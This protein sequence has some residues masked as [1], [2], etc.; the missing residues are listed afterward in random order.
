MTKLLGKKNFDSLLGSF[1]EKPQG[2]PTLVPETDKRPIWNTA[3]EDF[4]ED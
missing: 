1:I 4:K 3:N 2:K